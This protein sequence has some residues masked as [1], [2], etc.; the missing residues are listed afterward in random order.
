M[1]LDD[2]DEC[3]S[4]KKPRVMIREII[5]SDSKFVD[6]RLEEVAERITDKQASQLLNQTLRVKLKQINE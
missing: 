4:V 1:D 5:T 2:L 3:A 6:D